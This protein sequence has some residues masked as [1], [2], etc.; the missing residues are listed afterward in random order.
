MEAVDESEAERNEHG[1]AEQD[2]EV[3]ARAWSNGEIA[4]D[5]GSDVGKACQENDREDDQA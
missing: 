5:R 3:K 2:V 1:H 4:T